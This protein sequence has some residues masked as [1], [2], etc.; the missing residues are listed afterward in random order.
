MTNLVSI[1][2]QHPF[3]RYGVEDLDHLTGETHHTI[4]KHTD[5]EVVIGC[6]RLL[7]ETRIMG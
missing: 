3:L 2:D 5:L 1:Q 6:C 7:A 4:G